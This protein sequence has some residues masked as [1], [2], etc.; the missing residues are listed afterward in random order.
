ME[1]QQHFG[2]SVVS[3]MRRESSLSEEAESGA[4]MDK[5]RP[6]MVLFRLNNAASE[7]HSSSNEGAMRIARKRGKPKQRRSGVGRWRD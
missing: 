4:N 6:P 7:A 2:E 3:P 5:R 1:A